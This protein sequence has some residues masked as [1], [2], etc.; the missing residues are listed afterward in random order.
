MVYSYPWVSTYAAEVDDPLLVDDLAEAVADK[1]RRDNHAAVGLD[2]LG[3]APPDLSDFNRRTVAERKA[4]YQSLKDQ[5][6]AQLRSWAEQQAQRI[7]S[8]YDG[9]SWIAKNTPILSRKYDGVCSLL[10]MARTQLKYGDAEADDGKAKPHYVL[11][12]LHGTDA[13]GELAE[14]QGTRVTDDLVEM[15]TTGTQV[16]AKKAAETA[17]ELARK[18]GEGVAQGVGVPSWLLWSGVVAAGAGGLKLYLGLR[19]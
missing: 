19:R 14:A 3:D 9:L 10:E 13:A 8:R 4:R 11:A 7:Q 18:A 12:L 1:L 17:V 16:V 2:F 15:M 5:P 6:R